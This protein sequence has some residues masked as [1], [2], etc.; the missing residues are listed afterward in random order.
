MYVVMQRVLCLYFILMDS[1]EFVTDILTD[2][3]NINKICLLL[4]MGIKSAPR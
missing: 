4:K 1:S 2:E 3:G